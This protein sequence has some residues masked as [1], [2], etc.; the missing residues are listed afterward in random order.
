ML[1]AAPP[2]ASDRRQRLL[3]SLLEKAGLKAS[4]DRIPPR[5]VGLDPV[6]LSSGQRRLWFLDRVAPG[7]PVYNVPTCFRV[8]GPLDVRALQRSLNEIVR[9]H[10]ILRTTFGQRNGEPV[11]VIADRLH[12]PAPVIDLRGP[13]ERDFR[14]RAAEEARHPFDL[15]AGP[16]IRAVLFRL[17]EE[18]HAVLITM[19]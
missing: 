11:Q 3:A 5:P 15:A 12:V 2:V 8:R 19:H 7:N 16:L 6:P 18:D 9:R 13:G 10:E 17:A 1:A 14:A 4:A